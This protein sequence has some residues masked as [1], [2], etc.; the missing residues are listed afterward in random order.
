MPITPFHF[1]PGAALHALAPKHF[2]FVAFAAANVLIDVEPLY[3]ML[4]GQFHVH[5]FFHAYIGATLIVAAT[6]A[7]FVSARWFARRF[8]L[9]NLFLWRKLG[10]LPVVLGAAA[11]SYSH[12]L[13]DSFMHADI[14]PFAPF[15][16]ANPLHLAISLAT[17]HWI[18]AVSG[19]AALFVLHYRE[20]AQKEKSR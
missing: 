12:V 11:G 5:R 9:P 8:W 16:N 19:I 4:T 15:S 6:I 18:C 7:L 20:E 13:L 2:S 17:L 1:G 10:L 14:T 3:F